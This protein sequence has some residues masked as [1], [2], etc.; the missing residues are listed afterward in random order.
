MTTADTDRTS[1]AGAASWA[2]GTKPPPGWRR[3][4]GRRHSIP[5]LMVGILL[6]VVCAAG[7]VFVSLNSGQRRPVLALARPV[8]VGQV[9]TAP[10]LRQVSVAVDAGVAVV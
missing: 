1:P 4:A 8:Q 5:H 7:F 2:R 9:L 10:D 6:V 3:G